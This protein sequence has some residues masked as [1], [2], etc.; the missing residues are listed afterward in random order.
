MIVK[1]RIRGFICTTAHPL[2]CAESVDAQVRTV[3]AQAPLTHGPTRVLV[4]GCS[5]GY[6]LASRI[7][8][9]FGAGAETLGVSF[10]KA[11]TEGK[12]AS[13]GYYCNRAFE[14]AAA[15]EG[16]WTETLEGDAFS[17]ALKAQVVETLKARGPVDLVVYSLASPVRQDPETGTL[18]R[19]AIKPVGERFHVKTLNVDKGEVHEVDLEPATEEE[20][21]ATV[22]VM[23]GEDWERWMSTLDGAGLLAPGCQ[24]VAYTYIGSELT[25]PI[26]WH[27]TLG[28]AK[29]D[30]DRAAAGLRQRL[31]SKGGDARVAVLKAVVTQASAAIPVVPLYASLLFRVMKEQNLHETIIEHIWRLFE[32]GLY[33]SQAGLD[34][35]GRLRLDDWELR[36]GVQREVKRRWP[37][38]TTEN[39]PELADLDEF[40]RAFL[41]VFGF[42]IPGVDYEQ[43]V[44][45]LTI[46]PVPAP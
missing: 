29:E 25:W 18:W 21:A 4:L 24:T 19:S 11:P 14:R 42:A 30:L 3:K 1:P 22:K 26:Y 27:A 37:V 45:P 43:A 41:Q 17:D 8:A 36:E 40:R 33:G 15:R 32:T 28:K 9:A 35:V 7:S 2:G 44:N 46:E 13:A 12:T 5:A 34:E 6:G 20:I 31:A 16:L 23:G 38:V 39:L 10:E